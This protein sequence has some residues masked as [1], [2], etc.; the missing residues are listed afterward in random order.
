MGCSDDLVSSDSIET[1][2]QATQLIAS[3]EG[4]QD[5]ATR[6]AVSKKNEVVWVKSDAFGVAYT[7][8]TKASP[9]WAKFTTD[10][11]KKETSAAFTGSFDGESVNATYAVY[12]YQE[13]MTLSGSTLTMTLPSEIQ[14][15]ELSNGPM[16]A[17]ASDLSAA[18][19]F[20]HL[21]ASS[22]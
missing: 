1:Q 5:I 18:V 2:G 19:S 16:V 15:S 20:K 13:G 9:T 22:A 11:E 21:A 12:P 3:F 14:A 8:S 7:S 6:T 4:A 10:S 17:S